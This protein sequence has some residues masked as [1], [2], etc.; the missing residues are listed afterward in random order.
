MT[1]FK[2]KLWIPA[3]ILMI[4]LLTAVVVVIILQIRIT[5]LNNEVS[6]LNK[7]I[8]SMNDSNGESSSEID[9]IKAENDGLQKQI[10]SLGTQIDMLKLENEK[11]TKYQLTINVPNEN[12]AVVDQRLD[13]ALVT[14]IRLHYKAVT[15]G[16]LDAYQS[17]LIEKDNNFLLSVFE[18]RKHTDFRITAI[19]A[20]GIFSTGT[21]SNGP[22][23]LSVTYKNNE[24]LKID[25][26]GVTK[27]DGK[28]VVYYYD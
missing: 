21:L 5:Q 9:V 1:L 7:V 28:W 18:S 4:V 27:T 20:P 3:A 2:T 16:S 13:P 11:L 12:E 19:S 8:A 15:D 6:D 24:T 23:Y 26:L 22:F 17:T 14:L 10:T 25:S